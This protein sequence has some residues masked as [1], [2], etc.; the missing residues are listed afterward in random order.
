L[1]ASGSVAVTTSKATITG[2]RLEVDAPVDWPDGTEVEIH[3]LQSDTNGE[4]MSPDEIARTLAAMDQVIPFD[5]SDAELAAWEAERQTRRQ[6]D[7]AE[8]ATHAE[9]LRRAWE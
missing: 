8:F 7:K 9:E 5:M 4:S 1:E 6:C 2:R 3:P